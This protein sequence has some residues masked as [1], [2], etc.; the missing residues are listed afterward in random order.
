MNQRE[1]RVKKLL[2]DVK[3]NRQHRSILYFTQIPDRREDNCGI[4]YAV[5]RGKTLKIIITIKHACADAGLEENCVQA[6]S[7]LL[8]TSVA[9][10]S[11]N[12]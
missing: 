5:T 2:F 8:I 6:C 11:K 3:M 4:V 7:F 9:R 12:R 10:R 1:R